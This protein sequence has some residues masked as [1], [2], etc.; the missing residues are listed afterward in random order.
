MAEFR[1]GYAGA[2]D[3]L[4]ILVKWEPVAT[5]LLRIASAAPDRAAKALA[6]AVAWWHAESVK[7]I[8]VRGKGRGKGMLKKATQPFVETKGLVIQGGIRAMV[9]YAI[10]LAAGTRYI[11]GGA[12]MQWKPGMPT[13]QHWP[14]KDLA[15]GAPGGELPIILPWQA[16]ARERF[17]RELTIEILS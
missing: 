5:D 10:W 4:Q 17:S 1:T 16:E 14:A 11:A 13:I 8:P 6:R 12:V 7:H 2:V 15:G 9:P 3:R